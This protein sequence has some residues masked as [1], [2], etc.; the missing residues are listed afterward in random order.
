MN[1]ASQ[2]GQSGG[3]AEILRGGDRKRTFGIDP[4]L[5]DPHA[6]AAR[7]R[8]AYSSE[9]AYVMAVISTWAYADERSLAK[10]LASYGI[11]GGRVRR[12]AIRNDALFV[13]VTAYWIEICDGK[14]G[15]LGFR[16]TDPVSSIQ[17]LADFE[18]MQRAFPI[19]RDAP[20]E[21]APLVHAG[22]YTNVEAIWDDLAT[23][24]E[25]SQAE[26]LYITGHSLGAA[27]AVLAAA[28]LAREGDSYLGK[29]FVPKLEGVYTFGQPMVGNQG[30]ADFC[31]SK[32]GDR[33]FRH[34][35]RHDVVPHL[36]PVSDLEYVHIGDERRSQSLDEPWTP[37]FHPSERAHVLA[38][39][40]EVGF[41]AVEA[42]VSPS[43]SLRGFSIDDHVP[44][45]YLDVSK[46]S[47]DTRSAAIAA[48][49]R[50]WIPHWLEPTVESVAKHFRP[51]S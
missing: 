9:L 50:S 38:A 19:S 35:Y 12:I 28:A 31:Q 49:P 46:F 7:V 8:G 11:Q 23:W 47:M 3:D 48:K 43:H 44:S 34:V 2:Q 33:L 15:I 5:Q 6:E 45:K 16:G 18:A 21:S 1:N 39:L 26:H 14:V 51:K 40:L 29:V 24:I 27:M 36:P 13:Q 32:F 17:W 37:G 20:S 4:P 10:K 42:R 25:K 22:F 30:F 41:N